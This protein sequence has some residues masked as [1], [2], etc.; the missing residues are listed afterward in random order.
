MRSSYVIVRANYLATVVFGLFLAV[1]AAASM[2]SDRFAAPTKNWTTI[3]S[4]LLFT[5]FMF[6]LPA[7]R[8]LRRAIVSG[9]VIP[10]GLVHERPAVAWVV[11]LAGGLGHLFFVLV[12][13]AV[14]EIAFDPALGE[15]VGGPLMFFF[16]LSLMSY[17]ISLLCGELALVDDVSDAARK[18]R[19]VPIS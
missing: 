1:F 2:L 13:S 18:S 16:G 15:D 12:T 9:A 5:L 11:T 19:R 14:I 6:V 17:L 7:A 3:V 10:P 4:I 8:A